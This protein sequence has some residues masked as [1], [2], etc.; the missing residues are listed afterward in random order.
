[1]PLDQANDPIQDTPGQVLDPAMVQA[2][3]AKQQQRLDAG[4][5]LD[6]SGIPAGYKVD[7]GKIVKQNAWDTWG[8]GAAL[9]VGGGLAAGF[10]AG[11]LNG[12]LDGASSVAD[13]GAVA[14]T[15]FGGAAASA[16]P[17][18]TA[19]GALP[20]T[21]IGTGMIA[22]PSS[23]ASLAAPA[24]ASLPDWLKTAQNV[25]DALS[26]ASEGRAQGR[27]AEGA[28][29]QSQARTAVDLFNSDLAAPRTIAE[30][31]VRGDILSNAHDVNIEAPSTIPVPKISGGLHPDMFSPDT[32]AT[33][34]GLR[35]NAL[36]SAANLTP[37]MA[38]VLP[39]LPDA[40]GFDRFL[41]NASSIS[42]VT[43]AIPPPIW[44]AIGNGLKG[45]FT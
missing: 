34:V 36:A 32:R 28:A 22:A 45:L 38:P 10:G 33:G 43:K 7:G 29:N 13:L 17:A 21:T 40:G 12:L 39:A 18:G 16:A 37:A 26:S 14:P 11:A 4:L 1:M 6:R 27:L 9:T 3:I 35:S 44:G 19:V 24:S 15:E 5:P 41:N 30:N 23:T 8:K 42:G 2:W 25:G 20:S 31:A